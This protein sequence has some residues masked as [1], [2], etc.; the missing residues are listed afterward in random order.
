LHSRQRAI[1]CHRFNS[2]VMYA[3]MKLGHIK[4]HTNSIKKARLY[5]VLKYLLDAA[6]L[7]SALY[8]RIVAL[9]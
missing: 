3:Y 9:K 2:S 7:A 5:T 1:T 8:L 4:I 6:Y